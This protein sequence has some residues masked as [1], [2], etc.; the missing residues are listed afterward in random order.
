MKKYRKYES[1]EAQNGFAFIVVIGILL[2]VTGLALV[3]FN[4]SDTDRQIASNNLGSS[5]AYYAAEAGAVHAMA[6]LDDSTSWRGG[7]YRALV[8]DGYNGYYTVDVLDKLDTPALMDSLLV[9]ATGNAAGGPNATES[10]IEVMLVPQYKKLFTA[11]AFGDT[12]TF[13]GKRAFVNSYDSD[14]GT[15]AATA[16]L[17][18]ADI[19]S[20]GRL[21]TDDRNSKI[22]GDVYT[23]SP[24][25][26]QIDPTT[27]VYGDTT[28][29]GPVVVLDPIPQSLI[30]NAR[31]NNNAPLGLSGGFFFDPVTKNLV[32]SGPTTMASGTYYFNNVTL[33]SSTQLL[34]AP[35]AKV[36]ICM[37]GNFVANTAANVSQPSDAPSEMQIYSTGSLFKLDWNANISA[38]V[39]APN[40][41]IHAVQHN[42]MY[43][44]FIGKG[45]YSQFKDP[46]IHYDRALMNA[47]TAI[48]D[49]WKKVAWH[50]L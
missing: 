2:L 42:Q 20:N 12:F 34:L 38:A 35:G 48:F 43:G 14:S 5:R 39:Y 22:G 45:F 29:T 27:T 50:V 26:L 40:A 13:I 32:I 15:Y 41:L 19:G 10:V 18:S 3:S 25:G 30:D 47:Q 28:S 11:A 46:Y 36:T 49:G 44:S 4:T 9:R 23:S 33:N 21:I 1:R 8:K 6:V 37:V 7:F 17:N 16:R 24:G 31:N